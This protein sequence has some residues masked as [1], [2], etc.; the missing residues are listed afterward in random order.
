[1]GRKTAHPAVELFE[2]LSGRL[3]RQAG[4]AIEQ[5]LAACGDCARLAG[6]VRELKAGAQE[7]RLEQSA[8]HP[9][10]GE[11]AAFFYG[12]SPR[13]R[14]AATAAHLALCRSCASELALHAQAEQAASRYDSSKVEAGRVPDSA[15]ALIRDWQ[16]SNFARPK[17]A[18]EWV[19]EQALAKLSQALS[20]QKDELR[21]LAKS[22]LERDR[23]GSKAEEDPERAGPVPVIIVDRSARFRGVEIFERSEGPNGASIL[24]YP[25][26]SHRFDN[27]QFHALLDFGEQSFIVIS[28]FIKRDKVRLQRVTRPDGQLR[29]AD[30]FIV[31]D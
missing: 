27:K 25:E 2:Y 3:N 19:S 11:L 12:K 18:R 8:R 22:T 24:T 28:D 6:L 4:E 26:K 14:S 16:E 30:Y 31:E 20:Q 13:A 23:A 29:R 1:M 17:P 9:D 15:W 7:A 10:T 21:S 5:H